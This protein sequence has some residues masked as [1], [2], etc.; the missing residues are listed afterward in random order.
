[1]KKIAA[2]TNYIKLAGNDYGDEQI[3]DT[4]E[5]AQFEMQ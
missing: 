1:M 3:E 2:E 4:R 5:F